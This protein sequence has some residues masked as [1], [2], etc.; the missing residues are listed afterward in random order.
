MD[1]RFDSRLLSDLSLHPCICLSVRNQT[2]PLSVSL[3]IDSE[4][5][6]RCRKR[7]LFSASVLDLV[8]VER[9]CSHCSTNVMLLARL[10]NAVD[11]ALLPTQ[12]STHFFWFGRYAQR[13]FA[14]PLVLALVAAFFFTGLTTSSSYYRAYSGSFAVTTLARNIRLIWWSKGPSNHLFRPSRLLFAFL[15]VLLVVVLIVLV[16]H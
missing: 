14:E 4:E 16:F 2:R 10:Q 7:I 8:W 9:T 1:A 5:C 3:A 11:G 6:Q 13:S 12:V 15:F